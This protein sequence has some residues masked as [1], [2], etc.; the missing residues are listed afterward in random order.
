ML[1]TL[2]R[3]VGSVKCLACSRGEGEQLE[4]G[5]KEEPRP[6][7]REGRQ[8]EALLRVTARLSG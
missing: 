4:L 2:G 5:D 7:G 1:G 8:A 3:E 6:G